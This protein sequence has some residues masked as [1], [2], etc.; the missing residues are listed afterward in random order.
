MLIDKIEAPKEAA[1]KDKNQPAVVN[2][3]YQP[4]KTIVNE[5]VDGEDR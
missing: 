3:D 2:K 5:D 4:R 1:E